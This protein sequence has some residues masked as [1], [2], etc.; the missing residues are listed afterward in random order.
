MSVE[1]LTDEQV[2]AYGRFAGPPTRAQLE[3]SFFLNDADR[4]LIEQRRRDHNRLGLGVQLG[5]VRFLGTF[6]ADPTDV[7]AEVAEYVALQLGIGDPS[8]LTL[9][10]AREATHR[11]HAGEI[12]RVYGYRDF[13]EVSAELREFVAARA[14]TSN[15]GP[16]ALFNRAIAWLVDHKVLLPGATTLARL[17]AAERT[18]AQERLWDEIMAGVD[19]ELGARLNG[20]LEVET[21]SRFSVLERLRTSPAR[22]TGLEL[23]RALRRLAG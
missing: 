9:Y 5:T 14:W 15:D 4:E 13:S 3:R 6:L 18:A 8:C 23:E 2:A 16:R 7:P 11:E 21:G 12:Q 20:L 1:L 22:V 10:G 19:V 17:V